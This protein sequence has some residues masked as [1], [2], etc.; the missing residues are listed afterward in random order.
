MRTLPVLLSGFLVL[1]WAGL[2]WA[3][4]ETGGASDSAQ[5]DSVSMVTAAPETVAVVNK[6]VLYLYGNRVAPPYVFVMERDTVWVN[7][8]LFI[9]KMTREP[10]PEVVP[11]E[12]ACRQ[13]HLMDSVHVETDRLRA[14]G[15]AYDSMLARAAEMFRGSALIESVTVGEGGMQLL[16]EDWPFEPKVSIP[17]RSGFHIPREMPAPGPTVAENLRHNT[18]RYAQRLEKGSLVIWKEGGILS[19]RA[20]DLAK[21]EEQIRHLKE[22]GWATAEDER[23][24]DPDGADLFLR[25]LPLKWGEQK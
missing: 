12:L 16:W 3:A 19:I 7:G 21:A 11:T 22:R 2:V 18:T 20:A 10:A 17:L 13:F 14:Q 8:V 9:P 5:S 24:F 1:M 15:V 25:P 4:P 23:R 6:G